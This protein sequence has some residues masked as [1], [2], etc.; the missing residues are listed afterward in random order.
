MYLHVVVILYSVLISLLEA[1]SV[2]G[3]TTT[4]TPTPG[5]PETLSVHLEC[6]RIGLPNGIRNNGVWSYTFSWLPFHGKSNLIDNT[7]SYI[8]LSMLVEN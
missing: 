7:S 8:S 4:R 5:D 2:S 1:N 3:H 6:E